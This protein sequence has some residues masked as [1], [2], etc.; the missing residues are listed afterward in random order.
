MR[1]PYLIIGFDT[2]FKAPDRA[3]DRSEVREGQAKYRVLSCQ[4]HR[5]ADAGDKW[6]GVG[7]PDEFGELSCAEFDGATRVRHP[8]ESSNIGSDDEPE[9][10]ATGPG[11]GDH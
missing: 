9:S 7:C 1:Q 6:S 4:F 10:V 3:L 8:D 5:R 11:P 2:E